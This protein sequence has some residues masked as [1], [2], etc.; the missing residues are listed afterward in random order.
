MI[1][2]D[3]KILCLLVRIYLTSYAIDHFRITAI[4]R[5]DR[6]RRPDRVD[7]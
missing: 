5:G 3:G 4:W 6:I 1:D 2:L 7:L